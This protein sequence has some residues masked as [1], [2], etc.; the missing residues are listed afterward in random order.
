MGWVQEKKAKKRIKKKKKKSDISQTK[1]QRR[2]RGYYKNQ[3]R[4]AT[5]APESNRLI[6]WQVAAVAY[7]AHC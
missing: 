3:C 1:Q 4:K 6:I 7:L 5:H 2:H